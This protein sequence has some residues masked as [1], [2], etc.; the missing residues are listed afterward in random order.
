LF[1]ELLRS[2][3]QRTNPTGL[4]TLHRRASRWYAT[5]AAVSEAVDHAICAG[6]LSEAGELIAAQW[7]VCFSEGLVATVASWLDLLP[8]QMVADDA[9][10]C[11]ACGWVA[12]HT[13][14]LDVVERWVQAA[15]RASPK[16]PL[17][18]GSSTVESSACPLRAGYRYMIGDLAGGEGPARRA[19]HLESTGAPRWRTHALLTLGANLTWQGRIG[20]AQCERQDCLTF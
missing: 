14:H 3:L 2:E 13:G 5:N 16:G 8:A 12:R 17:R 20:E 15:E 10:L 6:D 19:L 4:S 7:N 9:R 18:D 11:L 1:A